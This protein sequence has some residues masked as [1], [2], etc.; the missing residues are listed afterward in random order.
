M[1]LYDALLKWG[2]RSGLYHRVSETPLEFAARLSRYFPHLNREINLIV[3][4][5]HEEVYAGSD[6]LGKRLKH[7]ESALRR[8][9]SPLYWPLRMKVRFSGPGDRASSAMKN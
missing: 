4:A 2:K 1:E 5:F 6:L 3:D 7:A 8:L 9:R